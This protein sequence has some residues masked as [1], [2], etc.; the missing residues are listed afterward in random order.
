MNDQNP[1]MRRPVKVT[2]QQDSAPVGGPEFDARRPETLEEQ[3]TRRRRKIIY[4]RS[5]PQAEGQ[6]YTGAASLGPMRRR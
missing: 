5:Q 4:E 1:Y 2:P 6:A 3:E